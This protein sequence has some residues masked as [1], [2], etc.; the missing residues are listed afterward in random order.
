ME[1]G[2]GGC[3]IRRSRHDR[4]VVQ[5]RCRIGE[6]VIRIA[7]RGE[8]GSSHQERRDSGKY[9]FQFHNYLLFKRYSIVMLSTV[10]C[11]A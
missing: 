11:E 10:Q 5:Q 8:H 7:A 2:S 4:A 1:G 9:L 6:I 3:H